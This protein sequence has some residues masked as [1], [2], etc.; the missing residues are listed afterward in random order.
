MKKVLRSITAIL[1][2]AMIF[3]LIAYPTIATANL[4][5]LDSSCTWKTNDP[6][7]I[8][9]RAGLLTPKAQMTFSYWGNENTSKV[10]FF[11][12]IET[13]AGKEQ[14]FSDVVNYESMTITSGWL[15]Y[16]LSI[17]FV[18]YCNGYAYYD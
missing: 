1:A 18:T 11:A 17:P 5:Y 4:V 3:T 2:V 6:T 10:F 15:E 7:A 9:S 14:H 12:C 16:S 13:N 8:T